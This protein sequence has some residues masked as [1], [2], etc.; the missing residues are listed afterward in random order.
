MDEP[1]DEVMDDA[2][3]DKIAESYARRTTERGGR[4]KQQHNQPQKFNVRGRN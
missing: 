4:R 3:I 2:Q 1:D